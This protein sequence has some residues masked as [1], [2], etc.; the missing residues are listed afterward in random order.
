MMMGFLEVFFETMVLI[1]EMLI[2]HL[3][4]CFCWGVALVRKVSRNW[5][6]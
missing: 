2:H 4:L 1:N 5:R 6:S 3:H